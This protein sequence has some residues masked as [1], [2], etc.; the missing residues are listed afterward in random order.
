MRRRRLWLPSSAASAPHQVLRI[1]VAIGG[2]T[3]GL[4]DG[5]IRVLD[6]LGPLRN[7]GTQIAGH[8]FRRTALRICARDHN[9]PGQRWVFEHIT[10]AYPALGQCP[11]A[12]PIFVGIVR[13]LNR[14]TG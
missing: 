7:F 8:L 10:I 12:V 1:G 14:R 4:L 2:A 9:R 5:Q 11:P 6:D 3:S 13:A